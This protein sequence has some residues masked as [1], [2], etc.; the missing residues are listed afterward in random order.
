GENA[1]RRLGENAKQ[2]PLETISDTSCCQELATLLVSCA[3]AIFTRK[4]AMET[5]P[6]SLPARQRPAVFSRMRR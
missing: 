4:L 1:K 2:S 3:T 6:K 5:I